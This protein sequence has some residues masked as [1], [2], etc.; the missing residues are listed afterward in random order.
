M[1]YELKATWIPRGFSFYVK[2]G[3]T[4]CIKTNMPV[5]LFVAVLHLVDKKRMTD[6]EIDTYWKQRK[7]FEKALPI[8]PFYSD[9]NSIGATTWFKVFK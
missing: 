7:Y 5:G 6:E 8:P 2:V 3:L 1:I 9:G 4:L